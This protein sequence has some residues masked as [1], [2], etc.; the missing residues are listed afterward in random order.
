MQP[1]HFSKSIMSNI[2]ESS[3]ES[4]DDPLDDPIVHKF[5]DRKNFA[6]GT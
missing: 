4:V 5:L 2:E 3:E 1:S 6:T